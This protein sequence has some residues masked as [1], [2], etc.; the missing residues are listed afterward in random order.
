MSDRL[1]PKP[2][3]PVLKTREPTVPPGL[4]SRA[5]MRLTAAACDGCFELQQC[6]S[7]GRFQY[8]PREACFNCLST[9][10][11]WTPCDGSG[12]LISQ[13]TLHHSNENYFRERLPL[14]VGLVRL[15]IGVDALAFVHEKC[16]GPPARVTVRAH[17]DRAGQAALAAYP[18]DHQTGANED[19]LLRDMTCDPKFRKV[20]VT[21]GKAAAGQAIVKALLAAGADLVWV[22]VAEPWKRSAA[23]DTIASLPEVTVV[24]LDVTDGRSVAELAG[25]IGGKVDILVNTAEVHRNRPVGARGLETARAEME[26]NY[27]GLLRLIETFGPA[28]KARAADGEHGAAAWVNLLSIHALSALPSQSSFTASKAAAFALSQ[29]LRADMQQAGLRVINVFP[30]PIDDEWNQLVPQ[31]KLAP[32]AL[33]DAIV[34]GLRDGTED[35]YPGD[36]A[37]D[38]LT[39]WRLSAKVLERELAGQ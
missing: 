17:L 31:P 38:F 36:V 29:S 15:D 34:A 18:A 10:L 9:M 2:K 5:A 24:P 13:T 32:A 37:R 39:R 7:C 20:L 12:E 25:L 22:G 6:R 3:N 14:R 11:E 30:G 27:F 26:V 33:A 21:D 16:S 1:P 28:L 4:R 23:L 35:I 8:P 19:R